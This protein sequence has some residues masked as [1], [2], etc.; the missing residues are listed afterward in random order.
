MPSP[1]RMSPPPPSAF[2]APRLYVLPAAEAPV[3]LIMRRGPSGWWHLLRWDLERPA[4]EAGAW[5]RGLLYPRRC[6]LSA[7]GRL[8]GYFALAHGEDP[9]HT[10]FAVSRAPWLTALAAWHTFGTWTTGCHFGRD[11][12]LTITGSVDSRPFHGAYPHRVEIEPVDTRWSDADLYSEYR[13]G[14]RAVPEGGRAVERRG[15]GGERLVLEHGGV[16][17]ASHSIEGVLVRYELDGV[18][19]DDVGWADWDGRGRLLVATRQ[20]EVAILERRGGWA[21][22]WSHDLNGLEPDPA[23]SPEWAR[24]W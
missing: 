24:A 13:R 22:T 18:E 10:Y 11:G 9:W 16:D 15:P 1:H 12:T 6:G 5:F 19:L 23:E 8:L 20:G 14:W 4:V 17:F 21:R 2:P 7:D 3:A